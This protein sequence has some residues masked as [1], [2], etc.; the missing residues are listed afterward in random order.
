MCIMLYFVLL[1]YYP[2][3][4][5]GIKEVVYLSDKYHD[6]LEM[7]AS[8]TLLNMAGIQCRSVKIHHLSS[9][10]FIFSGISYFEYTAVGEHKNL[11]NT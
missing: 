2:S 11:K 3:L 7:T 1:P 4:C 9:F 6:T 10:P 8:R 5:P